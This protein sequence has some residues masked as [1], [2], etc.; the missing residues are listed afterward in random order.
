MRTTVT[1]EDDVA[2]L[3]KR[4]M[5]RR[6]AG[7]KQLVNDALR[8]GLTATPPKRKRYKHKPLSGGE[9]LIPIDNVWE[10]I[11]IAEGDDYK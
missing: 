2:A 7:L 10:A 3:L 1:F 9:L 8:I 6:G 4:E 11:A 5:K